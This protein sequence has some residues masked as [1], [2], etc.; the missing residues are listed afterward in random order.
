MKAPEGYNRKKREGGNS[1]HAAL[2]YCP[3]SENR[4]TGGGNSGYLLETQLKI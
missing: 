2:L 4:L 3:T 1:R